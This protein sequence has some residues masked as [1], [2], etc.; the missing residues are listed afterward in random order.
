MPQARPRGSDNGIVRIRASVMAALLVAGACGQSLKPGK[1]PKE[2][3]ERFETAIKRLDMGAVYDMLSSRARGEIEAMFSGMKQVFAGIPESR[4]EEAG[5]DEFVDMSARDMLVEAV[6]RA[7]DA[8]P[9]A[10]E[11]LKSL[12][13]IV[14]K[15]REYDGQATVSVVAIYNGQEQKQTLRMV[16]E[17]GR[18][19]IDS[20][21]SVTSMPLQFAPDVSAA[22]AAPT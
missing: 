4:L 12:H 19:M 22:V 15:V 20:D 14:M 2:T 1:T 7:K 13:M 10:I 3:V 17:G 16:R 11:S 18:W 5:L 6:D 9:Q 8:N 21:D